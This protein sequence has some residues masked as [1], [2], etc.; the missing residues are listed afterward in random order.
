MV[1]KIAFYGFLVLVLI[2]SLF[3]IY[4][5]PVMTA[6]PECFL[7][8]S[9]ALINGQGLVN[10]L[11]NAGLSSGDSFLFYPPLFPVFVSWFLFYPTAIHLYAVIT[12]I[13]L[14]GIGFIVWHIV[15]YA[16]AGT[17]GGSTRSFLHAFFVLL[18]LLAAASFFNPGNSRPESLARLF[19]VLLIA[20]YQPANKYY[21]L[22]AGVLVASAG[23]TSPVLGVYLII[24]LPLAVPFHHLKF[25]NIMWLSAGGAIVALLLLLFYPFSVADLIVAMREHSQNVV[26]QRGAENSFGAFVRYH[27]LA[28]NASFGIATAALA[29]GISL[30]QIVIR[31]KGVERIAK[32][33]L[34]IVMV[35]SVMFFSFKALPMAYYLY[36]L[37][38][39]FLCLM[40]YVFFTTS[41]SYL[42]Y[43]IVVVL[44][45]NSI[46]FMRNGLVFARTFYKTEYSISQVSQK[47]NSY[48]SD[49][50]AVI[51]ISNGLWPLFSLQNT[52]Q[53][54]IFNEKQK[55]KYRYVILQ[56]YGT[57]AYSP[58]QIEGFD[59]IEN[60]FDNEE[61]SFLGLKI[62]SYYPYYQYVVYKRK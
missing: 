29:L 8:A 17:A 60:H 43:V 55:E 46:S 3:S 30:W 38:P 18:L 4:G 35:L 21:W 22:V 47:L 15:K 1:R 13:N 23:L 26:F 58:T 24:L 41:N 56:Q 9:Y 51:G 32:L 36:V 39:V 44:A 52:S 62:A 48:I 59:M 54:E 6:D 25:S 20:L 12:A 10:T 49:S 28:S 50:D 31:F 19:L 61:L 45:L 57:G 27:V 33:L 53:V 42:K 11:Y 2:F 14:M 5:F 37:V 34:L 7:P 16:G 40:G